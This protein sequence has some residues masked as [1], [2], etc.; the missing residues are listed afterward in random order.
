MMCCYKAHLYH[1]KVVGITLQ[2]PH[3]GAHACSSIHLCQAQQGLTHSFTINIHLRI[4]YEDYFSKRAFIFFHLCV[5]NCLED[6]EARWNDC[7]VY[8]R[9]FGPTK[10]SS[11]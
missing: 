6:K 8:L 4:K 9:Q 1:V 10:V 5:C 7:S 2:M 3:N 11:E